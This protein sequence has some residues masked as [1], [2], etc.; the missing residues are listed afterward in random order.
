MKDR[1]TPGPW[2]VFGN[3]HCVGGPRTDAHPHEPTTAGIAMCSM[4][5]RNEE[6]NRANAQLISAAPDL[7][8]ALKE[9]EWRG[10]DFAEMPA[11]PLC[12]AREGTD[13]ATDCKLA[14]A[15][16]DAEGRPHPNPSTPAAAGEGKSDVP[17]QL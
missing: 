15:I 17:S 2:F 8:A 13:H 6:E 11:C 5:A 12:Y 9:A 10:S 14:A 7:L 1:H 4:A 16:A 3:G